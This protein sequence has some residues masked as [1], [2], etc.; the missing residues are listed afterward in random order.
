MG[1]YDTDFSA[2]CILNAISEGGARIH[3]VGILGA[4]ML[5]LARL[6]AHRGMR[7]S[8]TDVKA[9][10]D[11]SALSSYDIDFTPHHT[12]RGLEG[13]RLMVYSLAVPPDTAELAYA[14]AR[15]IPTVTRA[16][17]LGAVASEYK[18]SIAVAGTHGKSTTVALLSKILTDAGYSPTVISGAPLTAGDSLQIGGGDVFVAEACE[19]KNAFHSLKPT[20]ALVTNIDFDH[21][22]FFSD[23]GEVRKSFSI[24]LSSARDGFI[25]LSCHQSRRLLEN[26]GCNI[27]TYGTE[28]ADY[29]LI[30]YS[31]GA[32]KTDFLLKINGAVY[33]FSLSVIGRGCLYDAV[34]AIAVAHSLGVPVSKIQA[35]VAAF[36]GIER[37]TEYLGSIDGRA[38]YYDYAHHPTEIENTVSALTCRHG[39]VS[40]IFRPHTY[41]RTAA[42]M[43][44]FVRAFSNVECLA[45]LDVFAARE[46]PQIGGMSEDLASRVGENAHLCKAENALDLILSHSSGAIVL[47]GAGEV[48]NLLSEIKKRL[49]A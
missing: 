40:V 30:W 48:D 31:L 44:G 11:I 23:V 36:S 41:S 24:F 12:A 49:D 47:M 3:F 45:L 38:V 22:D 4:G 1:N 34:G 42:L 14:R 37:R 46:N 29:A 32:Y 25:N 20:L 21:V 2:S 26:A 10:P 6:M 43:D 27:T 18:T 16:E 39:A 19:Y 5:P 17:L 13:T 8:G 35:S 15:G 7:V 9:P 33:D 28:G